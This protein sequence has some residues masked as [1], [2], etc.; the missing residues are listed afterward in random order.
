MIYIIEFAGLSP[1]VA[2][3]LT[4]DEVRKVEAITETMSIS[5]RSEEAYGPEEKKKAADILDIVRN[6]VVPTARI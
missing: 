3:N 2:K 1:I 6:K 4:A 5:E